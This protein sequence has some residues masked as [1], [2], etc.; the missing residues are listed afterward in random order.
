[1]EFGGSEALGT[2]SNPI[3]QMNFYFIST[4]SNY[5][6]RSFNCN[7]KYFFSHFLVGVSIQKCVIVPT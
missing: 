7:Q 4:N 5:R 2:I 6:D 3:I 1:M